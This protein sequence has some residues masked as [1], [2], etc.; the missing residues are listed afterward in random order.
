ML[1]VLLVVS[2]NH[3]HCHK[4][5]PNTTT[6]LRLENRVEQCSIQSRQ[7]SQHFIQ[8]VT[9][10]VSSFTQSMLSQSKSKSNSSLNSELWK[11]LSYS[12]LHHAKPWI[13]LLRHKLF[14]HKSK[15]YFDLDCDQIECNPGE[16]S[17]VSCSTESVLVYNSESLTLGW[18]INEKIIAVQDVSS[19][20]QSAQTSS[21]IS[22]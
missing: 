17:I 11:T 2:R 14:G 8:T 15:V 1:I 16:F 21:D 18:I 7:L 9:D 13:H 12:I 10:Q 20:L 19:Q 6:E 5:G 3:E 22:C 4:L